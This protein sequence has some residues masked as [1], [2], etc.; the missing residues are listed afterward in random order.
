MAFI[1]Y[2]QVVQSDPPILPD[3]V[4]CDAGTAD[5]FLR[6][7]EGSAWRR[8]LLHASRPVS[9]HGRE[10]MIQSSEAF[11]DPAPHQTWRVR[12]DEVLEF[13][14]ETDAKVIG[15]R[16]L[17]EGDRERL[18]F[19]FLHLV[20]PLALSLRRAHTLLHAGA[21]VLEGHAVLFLAPTNTGKST[22]VRGFNR[23]GILAL[24][25]DKLAVHV[26]EGR[27]RAV[28]AHGRIR[29]YRAFEDLG[30]PRFEATRESHPLLAA[31]CLIPAAPDAPLATRPLAGADAFNAL[32]QHVLYSAFLPPSETLRN[33][34]GLA[35]SLALHTI[36]Y[37][38]S[39]D[40]IGDV[41]ETLRDRLRELAPL[42]SGR[43]HA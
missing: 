27:W 11:G 29:D 1:A 12:V 36:T 10:T 7:A 28:S 33:L 31:F 9:M 37:P 8:K 35:N 4:D 22:L 23:Q 17:E 32:N 30:A 18:G 2:G 41:I 34:S 15:Y 20:L 14:W 38:G 39:L 42:S 24:S 19:W 13:Q 5:L 43:P 3:T 21:V 16:L 26:R 6:P 40:R 25:D